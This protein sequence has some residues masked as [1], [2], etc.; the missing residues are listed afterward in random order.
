MKTDTH[1][2]TCRCGKKSPRFNSRK[3]AHDWH[4]HH[5]REEC[6]A[7][8]AKPRHKQ[9][10]WDEMDEILAHAKKLKPIAPEL[11]SSARTSSGAG[12]DSSLVGA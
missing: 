10:S 2:Y 3:G 7:R 9:L 8:R 11:N 6:V 5:V 4:A 1:T 12:R